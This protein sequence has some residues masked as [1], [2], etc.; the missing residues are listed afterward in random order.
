[1]NWRRLISAWLPALTTVLVMP[2]H[3][4]KYTFQQYTGGLNSLNVVTLPQDRPGYLWLG[5]QGGLFRCGG[6]SLRQFGTAE[7]FQSTYITNLLEEGDLRIG[8]ADGVAC[9][10]GVP[11]IALSQSFEGNQIPVLQGATLVAL[12]SGRTGVL[13][14]EG[15]LTISPSVHDQALPANL[16]I[17]TPAGGKEDFHPPGILR[18]GR[19][20]LMRWIPEALAEISPQCEEETTV[21]C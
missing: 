7:G 14:K 12:A 21:T 16:S 20:K 1:M 3:A 11:T 2:L 19:R 18:A 6:S 5:T 13:P 17:S 15:L 10:S 9:T 8:A 4:Q